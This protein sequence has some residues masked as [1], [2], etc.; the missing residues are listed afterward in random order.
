MIYKII[1][2][3]DPDIIKDSFDTAVRE[4]LFWHCKL[5]SF[6]APKII[7]DNDPFEDVVLSLFENNITDLDIIAD[8]TCLSKEFVETVYDRLVA[9]SYI[10]KSN[11]RVLVSRDNQESQYQSLYGFQD[12]VSKEVLPH[13]IIEEPDMFEGKLDVRNKSNLY[14]DRKKGSISGLIVENQHYSNKDGVDEVD[15]ELKSELTGAAILKALKIKYRR[16]LDSSCLLMKNPNSMTSNFISINDKTD[17]VYLYCS[18][19]IQ[20]GNSERLLIS[21]GF[22]SDVSDL[23]VLDYLSN[24][25]NIKKKIKRGT[26]Y[27]PAFK[28][29]RKR[30]DLFKIKESID[31]LEKF[32]NVDEN[33]NYED[34]YAKIV[35]SLYRTLEF[36]MLEAYLKNP[37]IKDYSLFL[38]SKEN[39]KNSR[40]I[41]NESVK[42]GFNR[43]Q[44]KFRAD[45]IKKIKSGCKDPE[46]EALLNLFILKEIEGNKNS[47]KT[48]ATHNPDFIKFL[49]SFKRMRNSSTHTK[50]T[51]NKQ[52]LNGMYSKVLEFYNFLFPNSLFPI[53]KN[54]GTN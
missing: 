1:Q 49:D 46:M 2:N 27:S 19:F 30:F 18:K 5:F 12:T 47:L 15:E 21:D 43:C 29:N 4:D 7:K 39:L 53:G 54:D 11:K 17:D 31:G 44:I 33:K 45:G 42:I 3:E 16:D 35:T 25:T 14:L 38:P 50:A 52:D 9:K 51:D 40:F 6:T 37:L 24:S 34:R 32:G 23:F 22:D 26:N 36:I 8:K 48:F 28:N 13:F 41:T 20:K 10:D